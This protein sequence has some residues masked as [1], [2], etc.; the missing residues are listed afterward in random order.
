M[1][2]AGRVIES[3]H[4]MHSAARACPECFGDAYLLL[5]LLGHAKPKVHY[6]RTLSRDELTAYAK[7]AKGS[8][9]DL[10]F[11][12]WLCDAGVG[13][14]NFP[15]Y[16]SFGKGEVRAPP[17]WHCCGR[18]LG[19]SISLSLALALTHL[20]TPARHPCTTSG[21]A[22]DHPSSLP[23]FVVTL[24]LFLSV[25]ASPQVSQADLRRAVSDWANET[26]G[27]VL[28]AE[29]G[30]AARG[31]MDKQWQA[32]ADGILRAA[33]VSAK[34]QRLSREELRAFGTTSVDRQDQWFVEWMCK[35]RAVPGS[36]TLVDRFLK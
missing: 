22:F 15:T 1:T 14:D 21:A 4:L 32:M 11:I 23:H 24:S 18:S 34:N 5:D 10:L 35:K 26:I 19:A 25:G 30:D 9:E 6:S 7:T 3:R 12:E 2:A 16:D 8:G 27:S 36:D 13:G 29:G 17:V 33:D 31:A 28:A 20:Q